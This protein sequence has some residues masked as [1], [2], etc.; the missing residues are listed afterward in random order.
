MAQFKTHL[1]GGIFSAAGISFFGFFTKGLSISQT[2]AVFVVGTFGGL[3]PDLD[4]DTGKPV[5]LLFQFVSVLIPALI[6]MRFMPTR[7]TSPEFLVCYFSFSY[8]LVNYVGSSIIKKTTTHRGIMHSIPFALLCGGIGYLLFV[9][10]GRT[11]AVFAALSILAGCFIHFVLDE[12]NSITIRYGFI[13]ALK[14]SS[15]T[16]FKLK[17]DSFFTNFIIYLSLAVV[18]FAVFIHDFF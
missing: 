15:G 6:F 7:A 3:L 18:G 9:P 17:T 8:L 16:A 2:C 11:T 12:L 10:S 13:P 14:K 1:A 4:S 5:E